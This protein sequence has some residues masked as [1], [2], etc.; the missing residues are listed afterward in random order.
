M[1]VYPEY[2]TLPTTV[3]LGD[4]K[5]A[6]DEAELVRAIIKAQDQLEKLKIGRIPTQRF[7]YLNREIELL[8][9]KLKKIR[10]VNSEI[11]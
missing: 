1:N 4:L 7:L 9:T 5:I 8:E 6:I 11:P 10:A 3:L 2:E